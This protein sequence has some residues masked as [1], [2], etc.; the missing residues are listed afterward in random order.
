MANFIKKVRDFFY[1]KLFK[2]NDSPQK[3]SVGFGLGI[4]CGMFPGTGPLAA[5][6][7]AFIFRVNRAS[8]LL[9]SLIVNTWLSLAM[10]IFSIKIGSAILGLDWNIVYHSVKEKL[11]SFTWQAFFG[12]SL[13]NIVLPVFLGY[14]V[15]GIFLGVVSYLFILL[16]LK[17]VNANLRRQ[18]GH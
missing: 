14:L 2:I 16:A 11:S 7:L 12:A 18:N 4:F 8:A 3:I 9:A 15:T 13:V 17:V 5:L 10:F 1:E 6:F